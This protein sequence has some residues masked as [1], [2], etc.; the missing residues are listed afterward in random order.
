MAVTVVWRSCGAI[1]DL[2]I[3]PFIVATNVSNWEMSKY[4]KDY[5]VEIV[6]F[7]ERHNMMMLS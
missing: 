1:R 7:S 2:A 3:F 6:V 4:L 5:C